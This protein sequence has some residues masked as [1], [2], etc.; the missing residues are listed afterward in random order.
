VKKLDLKTGALLATLEGHS[1][2]ISCLAVCGQESAF[3]TGCWDKTV[4]K[5]DLKTG[6]LLATLQ[7]HSDSTTFLAA[8]EQEGA[9][10]TGSVDK[11]VKN[12]DLKTVA[13]LAT[14][15]SHS[16]R[17]SCLAVC[18]QEGALFP[19]SCD[20]TVKKWDLKTVALLAT[21]GRSPAWLCVSRRM[22]SSRAAMTTL[23]ASGTCKPI[24][25]SEGSVF[26]RPWSMRLRAGQTACPCPAPH[27]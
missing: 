2:W 4:K 15:E 1:D 13:L 3:F 24:S 7:G 20:K 9:L 19:G 11:T 16:E 10:L 25:A 8:C 26:T 21:L 17:I 5:W 22:R 18:G 12:W 23:Y 14:L 27:S 6:A